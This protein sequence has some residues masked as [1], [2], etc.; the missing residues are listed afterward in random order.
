MVG[1]QTARDGV[2]AMDPHTTWSGVAWDHSGAGTDNGMSRFI[3][4]PS[5]GNAL[6]STESDQKA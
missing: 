4:M 2:V 3:M 6:R 1:P 5:C